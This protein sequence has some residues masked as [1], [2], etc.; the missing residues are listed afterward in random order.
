MQKQ[1]VV[2]LLNIYF[3]DYCFKNMPKSFLPMEVVSVLSQKELQSMSSKNNEIIQSPESTTQ[4][5]T[6]SRKK[7]IQ[8]QKEKIKGLTN[9]KDVGS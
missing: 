9:W 6:H 8:C 4:N 5:N 7:A 3:A 1:F 2:K